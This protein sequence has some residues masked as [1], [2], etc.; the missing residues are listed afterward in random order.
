MTVESFVLVSTSVGLSSTGEWVP[1]IYLPSEQTPPS[2]SFRARLQC[3]PP[4]SGALGVAAALLPKRC[5][6]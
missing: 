6:P 5:F 3:G 1:P 4:A 2:G